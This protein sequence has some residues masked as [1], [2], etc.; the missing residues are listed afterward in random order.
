MKNT[1]PLLTFAEKG[2]SNGVF[3][4]TSRELGAACQQN[5]GKK[6][7]EFSS[8]GMFLFV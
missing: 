8:M 1:D 3:T 4:W 2:E 5:P 6:R 7:D